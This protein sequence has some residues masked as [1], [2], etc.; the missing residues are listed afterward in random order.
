MVCIKNTFIKTVQEHRYI[1]H[2]VFSK[3]IFVHIY[4][5]RE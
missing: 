4:K 2:T 3:T 5:E 1:I